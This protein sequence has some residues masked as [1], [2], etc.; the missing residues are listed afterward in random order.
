MIIPYSNLQKLAEAPS[1]DAEVKDEKI[2]LAAECLA[3]ST[4]RVPHLRNT[5]AMVQI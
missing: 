2:V 4:G 5:N 3:P 1:A